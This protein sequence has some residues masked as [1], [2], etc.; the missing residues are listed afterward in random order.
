[1]TASVC[2]SVDEPGQ[3]GLDQQDTLVLVR[4]V[5]GGHAQKQ[6][7]HPGHDQ[8]V[9]DEVARNP[10]KGLAHDAHVDG[11]GAVKDLVEPAEKG[12]RKKITFSEGRVP[13]ARA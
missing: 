5:A 11:A 12:R 6:V 3:G 9:Q 7:S 10:G 4:D 8:G 2:S 1:M 13:W